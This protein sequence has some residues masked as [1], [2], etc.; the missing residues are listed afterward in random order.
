MLGTGNC[1]VWFGILRYLGFFR[2]YNVLIL[3]MKGAAPNMFRFLICAFFLYIGFVFAG[4][5]ILGP[6]HFKF[7]T[8]M[9]TSE[10]L[11]SLI[12]GESIRNYFIWKYLTFFRWRHVC[13][14]QLHPG[15]VAISL[16]L[17]QSL[18]LHLHLPLHLRC[19]LALHLYHH[20][21]VW[22]HQEL[23]HQWIPSLQTREVLS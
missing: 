4:W 19:P 12:N 22:D 16:G 5:V 13:D 6:Y 17:Q 14:L 3:T 18:P 8:L 21:H 9:S 7:Q 11:F 1:L 10:C 15:A 20:G 23:L 2:T